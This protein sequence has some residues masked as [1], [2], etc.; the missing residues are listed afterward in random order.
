MIVELRA[1]AVEMSRLEVMR[2]RYA[3]SRKPT[4]EC[5]KY[6]LYEQSARNSPTKRTERTSWKTCRTR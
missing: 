1:A 6:T 4:G 2:N 3:P 5:S